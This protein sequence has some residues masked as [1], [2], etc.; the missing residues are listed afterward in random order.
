MAIFV[1]SPSPLPTPLPVTAEF[2]A[3]LGYVLLSA[4]LVAELLRGPQGTERRLL[5]AFYVLVAGNRLVYLS[6]LVA[7]AAA[8]WWYVAEAGLLVSATCLLLFAYAY[9]GAAYRRE[10]NVVVGLTALVAAVVI[11]DRVLGLESGA[12]RYLFESRHVVFELPASETLGAL[13]FRVPLLAA[14]VWA[15]AV[16]ARKGWWTSDDWPADLEDD[17]RTRSVT[18]A[19]LLS[20]VFLIGATAPVLRALEYAEWIPLGTFSA[21]LLLS[22]AASLVLYATY[23]PEPTSLRFRLIGVSL[24]VTLAVLMV[25]SGVAFQSA[26]R[27]AR[28]L[29]LAAA[30]QVRTLVQADR[31]DANTL[32]EIVAFVLEGERLVTTRSDL[33]VAVLQADAAADRTVQAIPSAEFAPTVGPDWA[34]VVGTA[35]GEWSRGSTAP[36]ERRFDVVAFVLEGVRYQVGVPHAVLRDRLGEVGRPLVLLMLLATGLIWLGGPLLFRGSLLRPIGRLRDA[37]ARAES[38]DLDVRVPVRANDEIGSLGRSFNHMAGAL[39]D[40]RVREVEAVRVHAEAQRLRELDAFRS[41]FFTDV[42]H[43][44]RTPLTLTLGPLR[45]VLSD[46][47]GR[48]ED[49]V[50]APLVLAQR[51]GQRV[52]TLVDQILSVARA[53]AGQLQLQTRSVDL[54]AFVLHVA[55][56]YRDAARQREIDLEVAVPSAPVE[57]AADPARLETV[58]T[59]LLTNAFKFTPSGG[60]VRVVLEAESVAR[61]TV[62]DTGRGIAPDALPRV[63]DRFYTTPTHDAF[64]GTGTGIGLSLARELVALHGGDLEVESVQGQGS[65]FTVTLPLAPDAAGDAWAPDA[66]SAPALEDGDTTDAP[67]LED[68]VTTVLVVEDHPELRAYVRRHLEPSYRV[69]EADDGHMGLKIARERLPDLVVS[70]VMMPGLDGLSLCHALKSDPETDFIPVVLLTARAERDDRI[71]GLAAQA[72]DYLTKPFDPAELRARVGNLIASRQRLRERFASAPAPGTNTLDVLSADDAFRARVEA[73]IAGHLSDEDFTVERLAEAVGVSRA[74]L[75]RQMKETDGGTPSAAIRTARLERAADLLAADAGTVS[76]VAYGVGFRSASHF[77]NTFAKAY[78]C[79]PS[80][81][82]RASSGT[83]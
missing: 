17:A 83:A 1:F 69:L 8:S 9:G 42:A 65:R 50:R 60:S 59:N 73:K 13:P 14:H 48:V 31:L 52:L 62:E 80:A 71:E 5:I 3:V 25:A 45:D 68:D 57:V 41:R 33:S 66:T 79:R 22:V 29:R 72:D 32:P 12:A 77:S 36:P 21:V 81:Y 10:R 7:A 51:S 64:G 18:G 20:V 27:D 16:L 47:H 19:R 53:E 38:G 70:D 6:T 35:R 2:V 49:A 26:A 58:L 4:V 76:E 23:A 55:E 82:A 44:F 56:R 43:E 15:A 30:D 40:A 24:S 37:L 46:E 39:Q 78:G 11:G 34:A 61:I 28:D 54:S 75:H 63:F 67:T 74:T